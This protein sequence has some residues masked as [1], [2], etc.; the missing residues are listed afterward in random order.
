ML[1]CK[2]CGVQVPGDKRCCPLCQGEL[3]GTPE[4]E[5]EAFPKTPPPR[6]NRG[7]LKKVVN[8]TA[9]MAAAV[10]IAVRLAFTPGSMWIYSALGGILCGWV[11]ISVAVTLRT[12]IFKNLTCELLL[13]TVIGILW[14]A[15]TGWR[16][17]SVDYL[18]PVC[19]ILTLMADLVLAR[20]LKAEESEYLIH[21][22]VVSLYSLIPFILMACGVIGVRVPAF[23]CTLLAFLVIAALIVFRTRAFFAE[24][25]RRMHI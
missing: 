4:P 22:T 14:D 13:L 11:T 16:G 5:K 10:C 23:I 18:L 8:F 12:R 20:V 21:L 1:V 9:L 25:S 3:A 24:L 17:W 15:F 19:C 2:K 7:M 6:Y